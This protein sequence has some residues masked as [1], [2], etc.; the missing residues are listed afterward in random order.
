MWSLAAVLETADRKL[1]E[2]FIRK[3]MRNTM[4]IPK[5]RVHQ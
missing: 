2:D 5:L 4:S 1:L 3:D